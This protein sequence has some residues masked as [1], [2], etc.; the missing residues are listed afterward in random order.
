VGA[1]ADDQLGEHDAER[2]WDGDVVLAEAD[3]HNVAAADD[4]AGG[5]GS[6]PG[7]LPAVEQ[8]HA[9]GGPVGRVE[10]VVVQ[11]PGGQLPALLWLAAAPLAR[12]RPG[13][14]ESW[15]CP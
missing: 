2:F 7:Q 5:H 15:Q 6:D 11:Q 3:V 9:S 8:D 10:S 13:R 1:A 14:V 12:T 4:L